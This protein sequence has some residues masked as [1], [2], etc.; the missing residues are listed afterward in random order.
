MHIKITILCDVTPCRMVIMYRSVARWGEL[1][2]RPG[3]LSPRGDKM[4]V[5]KRID[6]CHGIKCELLEKQKEIQ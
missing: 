4:H 2:G 1:Y 6:N 3:R 5:L